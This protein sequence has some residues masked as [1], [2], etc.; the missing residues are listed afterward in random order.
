MKKLYIFYHNYI[1]EPRA[2]QLFDAAKNNGLE[3]LI[4]VANDLIF[5]DDGIFY[6][7]QKIIFDPQDLYWAI[8]S[9]FTLETIAFIAS[10]QKVKVQPLHDASVYVDKYKTQCFFKSMSIPTPKT[11]LISTTD[12]KRH[13]S[14]LGDFP[15]VIKKTHS[16]AGKAV[17]IVN[18][19][20][21][22]DQF[23]HNNQTIK[24]VPLKINSFILQEFIKESAGS[25]YRVLCI[26]NSVLGI[27]KRTSKN[28]F[29]SNFSLGGD[30]ERISSNSEME[31]M[32]KKIMESS[33]LFMAGIDFIE[34]KNGFLAIEINPSPQF[35]GFEKVTDIDVADLI[36]KDLIATNQR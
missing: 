7:D 22:I 14:Q 6:N 17:D 16:S 10:L 12:Y 35:A 26:G 4:I 32:A 19:H 31:Y 18:S 23:I 29:K 3:P 9:T 5:T 24:K 36:I 15:L 20:A 27:I 30:V 28:G 33:G 2:K 13:T 8:S 21:E 1:E 11:V 25:D 34:S